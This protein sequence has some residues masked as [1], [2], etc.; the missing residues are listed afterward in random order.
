MRTNQS[1]EKD[2]LRLD[3]LDNWDQIMN[4][5]QIVLTDGSE[6]LRGFEAEWAGQ[7]VPIRIS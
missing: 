1:R 6:I 3:K 7:S 4:E 5:F 2:R